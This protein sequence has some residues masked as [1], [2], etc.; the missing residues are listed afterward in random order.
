MPKLPEYIKKAIVCGSKPI[1]R[2]WRKLPI[3]KLTEAEKVMKFSELYLHVSEGEHAGDP[4]ILAKFQEAFIYSVF[5]NKYHTHTAI[6]S[7]AR[8]NGKT[9]LTAAIAL[10]F[11]C[12][13]LSKKNSVIA[14]AALSRSQAALVFRAMSQIL[15]MSPELQKITRI[16]PSASRIVCLTN[17]SEYY[18]LS[19]EANKNLG[20]SIRV[21]ILDEAGAIKD[22]SSDFVSMLRTSQG[23]YH[24]PYFFIIS[25]EAPNDM[26]YLSQTIDAAVRSQDKETVVHLYKADEDAKLDSKKAWNDANPAIKEGFR[27]IE[28][29]AKQAKT[30]IAI[31][32]SASGFSNLIL[33]KRTS[34]ESLF[35]SADIWKR[36]NAP[37]NLEV[38]KDNTVIAGC[39]LS[40]RNDLTA[41]VL[42]AKDKDEFVHVL[43]FVF[44][45]T[46]GIEER[47][48][49]DRT[50]YDLW[51]KQ[52]YLVPLGGEVMDYDQIASYMR[53]KLDEMGIVVNS[54]QFDRWNMSSLRSSCERTSAF[55]DA[56]FHEV[57]TGFKDQTPR[58]DC[59]ANHMAEGRFKHGGHPLLTMSASNAIA[60]HDPSG[61]T[62]LSKSG[63]THR[64]DP[65]IALI[66]AAFPLLDGETDEI[67]V[68]G[69]I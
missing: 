8:R 66:M 29:I 19:A 43:P 13:H 33:N 16:I 21:L 61:N 55:M 63:S 45:P 58:C 60:V 46:A 44:C 3:D 37:I 48:R 57:G 9:F 28:D 62:K 50:P 18:S 7:V 6:M 69:W 41:I 52:G 11:L 54:I 27:S 51:V 68:S 56:D 10:C 22:P 24:E 5:D 32:A 2:N 12:G 40:K 23:S 49:R 47:S 26:A 39:D 53:D 67:D 30:A 20:R 4:L 65:L 25:T 36:N 17:G 38:F 15:D 34:M 31:P 35:L 59:L 14:S 64:I 42:C 1:I